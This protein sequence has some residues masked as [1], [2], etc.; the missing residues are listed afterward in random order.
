M[1]DKTEFDDNFIGDRMRHGN[2]INRMALGFAF[3]LAHIRYGCN[4][5][6]GYFKSW[7]KSWIVLEK[8]GH[9]SNYEF[10]WE[11]L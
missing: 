11:V 7:K 8:T 9:F 10:Q 3:R 1:K 6:P 5:S 2:K 4:F